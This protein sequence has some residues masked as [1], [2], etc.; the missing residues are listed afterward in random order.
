[1]FIIAIFTFDKGKYFLIIGLYL[2]T[3][4]PADTDG[5]LCGID[6]PGYPFLYFT[7]AP[8]MVFLILF[9]VNVFAF[10]NAH[11][12]VILSYL[13]YP[14]IVLDV[15]FHKLKVLKFSIL[16]HTQIKVQIK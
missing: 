15:D 7:Q 13:V 5:R 9:R 14:L 8:N 16:I 10:L 11:L 2:Q 1:M 3:N 12:K 4:F 6:L